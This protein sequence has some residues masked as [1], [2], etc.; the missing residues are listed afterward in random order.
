MELKFEISSYLNW[1]KFRRDNGTTYRQS[2][3]F[4]FFNYAGIHRPVTLYTT[5]K[6]YIDDVTIKTSLD[7]AGYGKILR[8][9]VFKI[10]ELIKI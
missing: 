4:D 6:S 5:P 10:L 1:W 8:E 2:Y 7:D 3:T 9:V